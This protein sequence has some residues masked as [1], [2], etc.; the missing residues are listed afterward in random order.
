[1]RSEIVQ[2]RM[3]EVLRVDSINRSQGD[4]LASHV[5]FQRMIVVNGHDAMQ[6]RTEISEEEVFQKFFDNPEMADQHQLMIVEGA[7]GAGKS[8]FIRWIHAKLK[9]LED[10]NE[11]ILLIR[12]SDNTLKG[13]IKQLLAIDEV[14]SIQNRE[15]YERL[16]RA[17]QA[18]S[19]QKLKAQIYHRFLAEI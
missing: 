19:E 7:S 4:F 2:R 3:K 1:M 18:I 9:N 5:P 13:T 10:P 14:Q 16:V 17:N 11:V 8:H 6:A 15:V 12:R